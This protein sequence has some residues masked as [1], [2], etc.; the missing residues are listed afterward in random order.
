MYNA[1]VK[2]FD[3]NKARGGLEGGLCFC[4]IRAKIND[5]GR[6]RLGEERPQRC[7]GERSHR[8]CRWAVCFFVAIVKSCETNWNKI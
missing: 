5:W 1:S 2:D 8:D 3:L 6:K 7:M 4:K